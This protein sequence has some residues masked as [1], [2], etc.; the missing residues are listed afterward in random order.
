MSVSS[1]YLWVVATN[2]PVRAAF[3]LAVAKRPLVLPRHL[4]VTGRASGNDA[5]FRVQY[6][7][8]RD[9]RADVVVRARRSSTG[10]LTGTVEMM[11]RNGLSQVFTLLSVVPDV[12]L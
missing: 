4:D 3:R 1:P 7:W 9:I 10:R 5:E 8:G 6:Q 2:G 11:A 12:T